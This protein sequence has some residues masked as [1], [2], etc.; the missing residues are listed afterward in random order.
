MP[1][2]NVVGNL[3]CSR[4]ARRACYCNNLEACLAMVFPGEIPKRLYCV[5]HAKDTRPPNPLNA[6]ALADHCTSSSLRQSF[7]YVIV[8]IE[9]LAFDCKKAVARLDCARIDADASNNPIVPC[10]FSG[11]TRMRQDFSADNLHQ[12]G[13]AQAHSL[14]ICHPLV[15][16]IWKDHIHNRNYG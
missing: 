6:D 7:G 11:P 10:G 12:R 4:F 3:P 9:F 2:Q 13:N 8:P 15:R 5:L 16:V 1:A 14:F